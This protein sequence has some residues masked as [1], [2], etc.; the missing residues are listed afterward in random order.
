[1]PT[2]PRSDAVIGRGTIFDGA[3]YWAALIGIYLM[4]GGL[5]FDSGKEKLFDDNGHAPAAIAKQFEGSFLATFPGTDAAWVIIGILEFGVFLLLVASLIRMEL[6][7]H[8]DK[9]VLEVGLCVAL[10]TFAML[11]FGQTATHQTQGTASLYRYFGATAII[12][13]LVSR[14]PPN[15]PDH[16]LSRRR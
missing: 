12:L 11:A 10:L 15:R 1:M 14:M 16:W 13:I 6:L 5:E 4:L 9:A 8:R 3:A 2:P 7:P